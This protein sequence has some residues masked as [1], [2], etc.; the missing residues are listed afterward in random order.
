MIDWLTA[1]GLRR[2]QLVATAI[3]QLKLG[4]RQ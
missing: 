2:M 1:N 3:D 4:D